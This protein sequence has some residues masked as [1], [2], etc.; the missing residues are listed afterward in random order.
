MNEQANKGRMVLLLIA[1]IPVTMLLAATWLW[2]YVVHGDFDLVGV[3]GTANSGQLI[4]PPRQIAEV[5]LA[6]PQGAVFTYAEDEPRW[7]LVVPTGGAD[8]DVVCENA[9][10]TTRQIHMATGKYFNRIRRLYVSEVPAAETQLAFSE[11]SDGRPAPA[12]F[13]RFLAAEHE[14]LQ[15]VQLA[16]GGLDE[17]FA[18]YDADTTTWFLVDPAGWVMMAYNGENDYKDIISDLKFLLKNSGG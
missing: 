15:A 4:Q 7:T 13:R 11:L 6:G 1:G 16:P 9:L 3:L 14:G 18:E 10:Y 17:L 2:Y 8:C 5:E 12:D